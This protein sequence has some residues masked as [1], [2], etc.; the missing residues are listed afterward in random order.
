V[1]WSLGLEDQIRADSKI[2]FLGSY[3]PNTFGQRLEA[4]GVKP[5]DYDGFVSPIPANHNTARPE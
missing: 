2:D 5:A 4:K 3:Q 1:Y